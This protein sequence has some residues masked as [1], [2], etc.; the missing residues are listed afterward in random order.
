MLC[1]TFSFNSWAYS[2][3]NNIQP[4]VY[5]QKKAIL[6]TF[7]NKPVQIVTESKWSN[8]VKVQNQK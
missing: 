2:L 1:S 8:Q 6:I 3:G 5:F 4:T 7:Q